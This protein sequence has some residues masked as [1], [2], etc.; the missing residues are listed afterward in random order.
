MYHLACYNRFRQFAFGCAALLVALVGAPLA[1]W[2]EVHDPPRRLATR[3]PQAVR[4]V[5]YEV[6]ADLAGDE[7]VVDDDGAWSYGDGPTAQWEY[8]VDGLGASMADEPPPAHLEFQDSLPLYPHAG[9]WLSQTGGRFRGALAG[10][11]PV[12]EPWTDV[13]A[14][15]SWQ[16]LPDG[17]LYKQYL[18]SVREPRLGG[19]WLY[20]TASGAVPWDIMLGGR[21]G[22]LRWGSSGVDIP[23]GRPDG[24]QWDAEGA[25]IVRLDLKTRRDLIGSDFRAGTFLTR[26]RGPWESRFG[27][28][29]LSAHAGD[30]FLLRTPGFMRINY[31]RDVL[32]LGI[33]YR[34]GPDV[35][36]YSEGG[37]S[38]ANG[39]GSQPWEFQFGAD[40]SPGRPTLGLR[41]APFLAVNGHLREELNFGGNLVVQAGWQWRSLLNGHL[42][43]TGLEYYHGK[44]RQQQ[45]FNR[46][47]Q[48]IGMGLWYDY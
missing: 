12:D 2:A 27:Y 31:T 34:I 47:E 6:I 30:E 29:H 44:S 3:G 22:L 33:A 42:L 4:Q 8:G 7:T 20:D 19:S 35:R 32:V 28:Y 10:L 5:D 25:A 41:P 45:L 13:A 15:R 1:A 16:L 37:Y 17:L 14:D 9:Q 24:W 46:F 48:Q 11:M 18:A 36:L 23:Y 26:A 39:G 43:R 21:V 38:V 40:Y